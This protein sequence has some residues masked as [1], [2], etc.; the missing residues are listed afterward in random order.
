[1]DSIKIIADHSEE[2]ISVSLELKELNLAKN[3][4]LTLYK[5]TND[6]KLVKVEYT[7]VGNTLRFSSLP[8][9]NYVIVSDEVDNSIMILLI[10]IAGLFIVVSAFSIVM[11]VKNKKLKKAKENK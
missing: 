4:A 10:V 2:E 7:V 11:V 3:K 9:T 5:L 8:N 6:G 1:M